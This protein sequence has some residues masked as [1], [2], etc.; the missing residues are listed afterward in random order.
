M[1]HEDIPKRKVLKS[2]HHKEKFLKDAQWQMLIRLLVVILL[3]YTQTL[4][5]YAIRSDQISRSVVSDS[6]RPHESQHASQASLSITNS[7]SSLRYHS[8][9][10]YS[11]PQTPIVV[12]ANWKWSE[13]AQ[14]CPTLCDPMDCG[15]SGSSVHGVFQARVLEWIAISFSR[16][17]SWPR[18]WTRV[19]HIAGRCFT[20]WVTR[21][22]QLYLD[23]T[24]KKFNNSY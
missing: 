9:L 15:L 18:D 19:S 7:R 22:G 10:C 3:Q 24:P 16:G 23:N 12:Y 20:I 8:S 5:C 13:V 1:K 14:L 21:E 2:S 4:N 11:I 17:S 6:S